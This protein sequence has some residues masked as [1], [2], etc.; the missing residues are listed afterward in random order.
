MSCAH[1]HTLLQYQHVCRHFV[2]E[3]FILCSWFWM[4]MKRASTHL[5]VEMWA[6]SARLSVIYLNL[7]A[8]VQ[9]A[10]FSTKSWHTTKWVSWSCVQCPS[11]LFDVRD[12]QLSTVHVGL[13]GTVSCRTVL[14]WCV[15]ECFYVYTLT[16]WY[17]NASALAAVGPCILCQCARQID[18]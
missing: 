3:C 14:T 18:I 15:I 1:T 12:L 10:I 2:T 9:K 16:D 13:H 7:Q 5:I 17:V 6:G 8:A 11:T 4:P